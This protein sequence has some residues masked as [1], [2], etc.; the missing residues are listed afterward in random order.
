MNEV[1]SV[2]NEMNPVIGDRNLLK[3]EIIDTVLKSFKQLSK[4]GQF[5]LLGVGLVSVVGLTAYALK[6]DFGFIKTEDGW[7][8]IKCTVAVSN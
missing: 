6:H 1:M 4:K 8:V 7:Q 5:T 2:A 3:K